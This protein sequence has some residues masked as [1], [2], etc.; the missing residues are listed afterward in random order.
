MTGV[1]VHYLSLAAMFWITITA[2]YIELIYLINIISSCDLLVLS[3][4]V[5]D[6]F[7]IVYYFIYE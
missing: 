3:F 6:V 5:G 7:N 1:A 2:K 4:A